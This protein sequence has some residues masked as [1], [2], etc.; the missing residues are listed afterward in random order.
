M[1]GK[2]HGNALGLVCSLES[3]QAGCILGRV[4]KEAADWL[5]AGGLSDVS[6]VHNTH[7]LA[8]KVK[9]GAYVVLL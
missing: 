4:S 1:K 8:A 2:D 6:V 7:S 9:F 5:L 3:L